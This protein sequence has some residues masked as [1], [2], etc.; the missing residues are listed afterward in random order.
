MTGRLNDKI[1]VITGA[2]NGIGKTA[3]LR[4]AEQGCAVAVADINLENAWATA[5]AI[6]QAGGKALPIA[7]D[8]SD[9]E[10]IAAMY[11]E[12][13]RHFGGIDILFNNAAVVDPGDK[14]ICDT[15]LEAWS[16]TI[17]V[18]LTGVFLC[19]NLGIPALL[20]RNGGVILNTAS[21]VA[22]VGST[23]SQIAYT[24]S[25]GGVVAMTREIAVAYARKGIRANSI[26]PGVTRTA[27]GDQMV[28][29]EE[30]FAVRRQH[31]PMG[32]LAEPREIADTALYLCSDEAS[33]VTG[34]SVVVD[35]GLT[36]AYLCPTD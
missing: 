22:L 21:I 2:A 3:A 29:D 23:P 7:V 5:D 11:R 20:R 13:E 4:F 27:M 26:L 10:S 33:F 31:M 18:N 19:C 6:D 25:K 32:R 36:S 30:G 14:D 24:A 15:S 17:A 16:K 9:A 1:A 12:T 8:V 34:Q 28:K 35:G